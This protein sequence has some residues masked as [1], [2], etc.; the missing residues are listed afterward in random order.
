MGTFHVEQPH[1]LSLVEAKQRLEN[2]A[3]AMKSRWGL[4]WSWTSYQELA[5]S[6]TG[7][8]GR[9]LLQDDK[10]TGDVEYKF[11]VEPFRKQIEDAVRAEL[12][13]ALAPAR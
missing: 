4:D 8:G 10:V 1:T 3:N 13:R 6:R 9:F 12:Q 5:L 2:L 11:F 7:I